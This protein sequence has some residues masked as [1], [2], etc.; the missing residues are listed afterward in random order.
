MNAN[1]VRQ[2]DV[3]WCLSIL[4]ARLAQV[5]SA[6][7]HVSISGDARSGSLQH[8]HLDDEYLRRAR[9]FPH[10]IPSFQLESLTTINMTRAQQTISIALLL[11]SVCLATPLSPQNP[12]TN[13]YQ[14]YLAVFTQLV[15]LPEK[16]QTE[17]VPVVCPR[18]V[19]TTP[20]TIG[21]YFLL[22]D[23]NIFYRSPS[24]HSSPSALTFYSNSAGEFSPSTTYPRRTRN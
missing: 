13:I 11:T 5:G 12:S 22:I 20:Y 2:K 18:H 23:A 10:P 14:L 15:P 4:S 24:G 3:Q 8:Q 19:S 9:H 16:I 21:K 7:S 17:I 1:D 6:S